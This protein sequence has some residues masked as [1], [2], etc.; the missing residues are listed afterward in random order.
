MSNEKV[1]GVENITLYINDFVIP[2]APTMN[3]EDTARRQLMTHECGNGELVSEERKKKKNKF[4]TDQ[5]SIDNLLDFCDLK[6]VPEIARFCGKSESWVKDKINNDLNFP[7]YNLFGQRAY[8]T[9]FSLRHYMQNHCG[10]SES[11]KPSIMDVKHWTDK[12]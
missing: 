10:K 4:E 8:A 3:S 6:G 2:R 11:W 5:S 7:V 1:I 9:Q 12:N